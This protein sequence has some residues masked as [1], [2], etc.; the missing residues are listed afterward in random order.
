MTPILLITNLKRVFIVIGQSKRT[1]IFREDFPDALFSKYIL[2][3][4]IANNM[5]TVN[6]E[7]FLTFIVY[8]ILI[9]IKFHLY[10]LHMD[11]FINQYSTTSIIR[12]LINQTFRLSEHGHKSHTYITMYKSASFIR[13]VTYLNNFVRSQ[14]VRIIEVA[15]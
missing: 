8:V 14:R 3:T 13:T 15:L 6:Y 5:R 2:R 10:I 11:H 7:A 1:G 9:N 12:T 4:S